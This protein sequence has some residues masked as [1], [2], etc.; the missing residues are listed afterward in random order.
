MR[1]INY[2]FGTKSWRISGYAGIIS[3]SSCSENGLVHIDSEGHLMCGS[4]ACPALRAMREKKT[5]EQRIVF[6]A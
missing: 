4:D 1:I 6:A 5:I 3:S 2:F